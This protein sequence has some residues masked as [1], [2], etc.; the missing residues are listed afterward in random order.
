VDTLRTNPRE[1]FQAFDLQMSKCH[2]GA[3]HPTCG[4]GIA[5]AVPPGCAAGDTPARSR[6]R[7]GLAPAA[8]RTGRPVRAADHFQGC[9]PKANP[10]SGRKL[11]RLG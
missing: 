1:L 2:D 11:Q 7:T 5:T 3:L 8:A 10:R 6:R 4:V 9:R